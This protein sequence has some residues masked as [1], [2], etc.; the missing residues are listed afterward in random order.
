[1][2]LWAGLSFPQSRVD[3]GERRV[4][5][6]VSSSAA[7]RCTTMGLP[8]LNVPLLFKSEDLRDL[9][10]APVQ[11]ENQLKKAPSL[12]TECSRVIFGI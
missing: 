1:M 6:R 12:S 9:Q 5:V 8:S 11:S 7:S 3:G 10:S 4:R 2:C